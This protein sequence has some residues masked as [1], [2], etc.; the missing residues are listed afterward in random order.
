MANEVVVR[1]FLL[2]H[3][4]FHLPFTICTFEPISQEGEALRVKRLR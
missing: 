4:F 1:P 3:P 2:E